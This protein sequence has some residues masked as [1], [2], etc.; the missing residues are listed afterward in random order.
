MIMRNYVISLTTAEDRRIHIKQEFGKQGIDF[1]FFDAVTPI[2]NQ[3]FINIFNLD[4]TNSDLSDNEILCFLSH[5]CLWQKCLDE[6]LDYIAIFEDDVY[7][8]K[9]AQ[10]FLKNCDWI[11]KDV[12]IIK[13]EKFDEYCLL[14]KTGIYKLENAY[15][16][17]LKAIHYGTA[18]YI[19]SNNGAKQLIDFIKHTE[20]VPID[21]IMFE[22]TLNT[23]INVYQINPAICIIQSDRLNDKHRTVFGS[24]LEADRKKRF[25][26]AKYPHNKNSNFLG[27]LKKEATRPFYQLK[28]LAKK[29]FSDIQNT[30]INFE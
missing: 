19:L 22:S 24:E 30:K 18:G 3:S 15:L 16:K 4:F 23:H 29:I 1:E 17:I 10:L 27:K 11:P 9:N 12:H 21:H 13:I 5:L 25:I 7:L 8:S 6:N 28:N 20:V 2:Y 14:K 26:N